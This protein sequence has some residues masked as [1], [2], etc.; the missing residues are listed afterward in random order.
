MGSFY[1]GPGLAEIN[2]WSV[3]MTLLSEVATSDPYIDVAT[4]YLP[5]GR[6]VPWISRPQFA[7]RRESGD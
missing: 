4:E 6:V 3:L 1:I 2:L 7:D 5:I